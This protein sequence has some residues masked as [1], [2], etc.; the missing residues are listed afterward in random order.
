MAS[1]SPKSLCEPPHGAK[2][3][4]PRERLGHVAVSALLLAPK[5]VA[6]RSLGSHHNHGNG[7]EFRVSLQ[8]TADLVSVALWHHDVKQDHARPLLTDGF[9]YARGVVQPHRPVAFLLQKAL[10]QLDFGR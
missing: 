5:P 10:D 4:I 9:F 3:F 6:Y 7:M 8:V 2:Q 1:L